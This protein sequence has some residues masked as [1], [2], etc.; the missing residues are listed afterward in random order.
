PAVH[1]L[2]CC[3]RQMLGTR[4]ARP[5]MTA[6][7][8]DPNW[9]GTNALLSYILKAPEQTRI[10]PFHART[11]AP[12]RGHRRRVH[13]PA[14]LAAGG[15]LPGGWADD[16]RLDPARRC[17]ALAGRIRRRRPR[18]GP[19]L[20]RYA[21]LVRDQFLERDHWPPNHALCARSCHGDHA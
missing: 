14:C 2:R 15:L 7:I 10:V 3:K 1:V 13:R 20:C 6:T 17:C 19:A 21:A 8:V 9:L 16:G 5:G 18:P 12:R 4:R 11:L